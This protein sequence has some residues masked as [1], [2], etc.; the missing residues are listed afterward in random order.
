MNLV[1]WS[2]VTVAL[3]EDPPEGF[4]VRPGERVRGSASGPVEAILRALCVALR[5]TL[6]CKGSQ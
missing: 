3:I 6:E 1:L 2:L 4:R 5:P